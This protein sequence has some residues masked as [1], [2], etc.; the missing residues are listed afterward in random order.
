MKTNTDWPK[1][2]IYWIEDRTLY[3]SIPFTWELT[4]VENKL[5]QNSF[6]WDQA[7]VGGPAVELISGMFNN[8][9]NVKIGYSYTGILQRINPR[10]TR[11]T[12]GCPRACAFCAVRRLE[13]RFREL[14]DWPDLPVICDNNL[15][16]AS[17]W[18]F[19][20]V[21]ERLKGHN[22]VEFSFGLDARLLTNPRAKKIASLNLK[23]RG[24]R[25]AL[26]NS[27]Y[28][29]QWVAAVDML[30]AAG[31]AKR[32]IAS[33]A[34]VGFNSGPVE[35]W[36]RCNFIEGHGVRALPVWFHPLDAFRKNIVTRAQAS[37]GWDDYERRRIMQWFYQHKEAVK[38]KP[39]HPDPWKPK[40]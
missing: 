23:K 21:I 26:D 8:L 6:E 3:A 30:R 4:T 15:L 17:D 19:N 27:S 34:L 28:A 37:L 24:V 9:P 22:Q 40:H 39:W 14:D 16:A 7:I 36:E 10:A 13:G 5:R 18:H 25:V 31:I 29:D 11:T 32:N 1:K 33:F 35:A 20:R 38:P 12:M 2:T